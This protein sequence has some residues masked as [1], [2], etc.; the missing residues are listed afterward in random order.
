MTKKP[1]HAQSF[2]SS[3]NP[4]TSI[5]P[6]SFDSEVINWHL[7]LIDFEFEYG[8]LNIDIETFRSQIINKMRSVELM[9]WDQIKK[10][11]SHNIA[12]TSLIPEARKRLEQLHLLD[13]GELFSLRLSGIERIW[14]IRDKTTFKVLWWDPQHKICPSFKKNT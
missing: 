10:A 14:G 11:D 6:K 5:D 1:V 13:A 2:S 7:R 3:K 9:T 8:W 12:I 4:R